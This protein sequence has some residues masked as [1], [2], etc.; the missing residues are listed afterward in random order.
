MRMLDYIYR[1]VPCH[2]AEKWL[3]S[4]QLSD[5]IEDTQYRAS[6]RVMLDNSCSDQYNGCFSEVLRRVTSW[7]MSEEGKGAFNVIAD[8]NWTVKINDEVDKIFGAH[9]F[10]TKLFGFFV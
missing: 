10:G 6:L 1:C 7:F 3:K 8:T 4:S 2:Y 9:G 5:L